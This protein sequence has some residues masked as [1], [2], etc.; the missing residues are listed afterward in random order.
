M[1]KL[2]A[3]VILLFL[4]MNSFSINYYFAASGNDIS[5]TGTISLPWKTLTKFNTV[6]ASKAPGDNFLFNR[7]DVF[8]GKMIISRS[9]AAGLPITIGAYG[10]GAMPVLNGFTA[11]SAWT[12]LGSNIWE[13]TSAVS[14]L[15]TCNM[16]TVN[17]INYAKGRYP[18]SDYFPYQSFTTNTSITSTSVSSAITNWAVPAGA[19]LVVRKNNYVT[20]RCPITSMVGST[21]SYTS[22]SLTAGINGYGFFIQNDSRTLDAINEW[23]YNPSTKKIRI[24]S[25]SSPVNVQ[26]STIDTL[27]TIRPTSIFLGYITFDGISF[28]GAN[29]YAFSVSSAHDITIKNCSINFSGKN[30]VWGGQNRGAASSNFIFQDNTVNHTN[31]IALNLESEF[32]GALI[33]RNTISN[34]G[35][36]IGMGGDGGNNEGTYIAIVVHAQ[37]VVIE[38]NNI[39]GVGY[40]GVAVGGGN[41]N[42]SGVLVRYNKINNFCTGKIDGAGVYFFVGAGGTPATGQKIYNNIVLNGIGSSV[43]TVPSTDIPVVHGVYLDE[44]CA[45]VEVY[46]N[47]CA[48]NSFSGHYFHSSYTCNI[49]DNTWYNNGVYQFLNASFNVAL[50]ERTT[51]YKNNIMFS[52]TATQKA[53]SYET[54]VDDIS[55]FGTID[56]NYYCRPID[57]NLTIQTAINNYATFNQ[58]SLAMWKVYQPAYDIHSQ[59][60]PATVTNVN[61]IFFCYN[62]TDHDSTITLPG[63]YIDV[64]NV[65]YPGVITLTAYTSAVLINTGTN[66]PPIANAGTDKNITLPTQTVTQAG[67]GTDADGTVTNYNW[68]QVSG[69][70]AVT[71]GSQTSATTTINNLSV[72]GTYVIQLRVTDNLGATGLDNMTIIVNAAP[73]V[74]VPPTANAG[75]NKVITLPTNLV[76]QAGSGTDTDGTITGYSWAKTSGP[77]TYTIVSPTSATTVINNLIAGTYQFTLTV[78]D[79]NGATGSAIATIIVNIA[80]N[81]PPVAN[82]GSDQAATW[83]TNT[84][85]LTGGGTDA[86]GTIVAYEW[87]KVSGPLSYGISSAGSPTT[88]ITGLQSGGVY[89]FQLKVTDNSGGVDSDRVQVTENKGTASLAYVG[90]SFTQTFNNT[91]LQPTVVTSPAGLPTSTTLGGVTGG[92]VN[93]GTYPSISNITDTNYVSTSIS[94]VFTINKQTVVINASNQQFNYDGLQHTITATTTPSVSGLTYTYS[95]GAAPTAIGVYN[96]TVR[97]QNVNYQATPVIVTITIVNNPAPIFISDTTFI[98]N[99]LPHTVTVTSAYSYSITG[100]TRTNAGTQ[101][102]IV[103]INDGI[104]VGTDTANLTV[105]KADPVLSWAQPG[106]MPF[107]S[108]LTAQQLNATSNVAGQIQYDHILG[109]TLPPGQTIIT[110]TFTPTDPANYNGGTIQRTINVYLVNPFTNKYLIVGPDGRILFIEQ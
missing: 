72:A 56:S 45:N 18:N 53:A 100:G 105:L 37:N 51:I 104:H 10:T 11:V 63:N 33:S 109:E 69:P 29:I 14:G 47:T 25:T 78:T 55:L 108:M 5:G 110:G 49:H 82:A 103:N 6:F 48:G 73:P 79:N 86:D 30:A 24:Y 59:K 67:S 54:R 17:G 80:P 58:R 38:Y 77:A 87:S 35:L 94:A 98:F 13:S 12:D 70:A 40:N 99:N 16:V 101:Q 75:G 31:N 60:S 71:F 28:T 91:P 84:V 44:G 41:I 68:T 92:K 50:P 23:Y 1:K 19:E 46:N 39:D 76:T 83:P 74:N 32:A 52:K 9:G 36:Q 3:F 43:G 2:F 102:V 22:P 65:V 61:Q 93:A 15:T 4:C 106:N 42:C 85:T 27:V 95:S 7:G 20:D 34:T 57:D 62:A 81:T 90:G 89:Q 64:K 96:D 8:Y 88:N 107:G 97:L 26:V 66:N 21:I